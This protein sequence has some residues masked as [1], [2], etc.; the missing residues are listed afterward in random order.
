MS[1]SEGS[2][3]DGSYGGR[4]K[5]RRDEAEEVAEIRFSFSFFCNLFS[6]HL[7]MMLKLYPQGEEEDVADEQEPEGEDLDGEDG[8]DEEVPVSKS[9]SLNQFYF[10]G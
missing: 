6:S 4:K 8:S 9:N 2:D 7:S 5:M 3:S 1:D 10:S